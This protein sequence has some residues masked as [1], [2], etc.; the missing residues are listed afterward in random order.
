[1]YL[2][3]LTS[4]AWKF[5]CTVC[6]TDPY[7]ISQQ[8]L[9]VFA[10]LGIDSSTKSDGKINTDIQTPDFNDRLSCLRDKLSWMCQMLKM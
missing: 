8:A 2:Y 5:I 9:K 6:S 1:M 4:T 10:S 3:L 7:I